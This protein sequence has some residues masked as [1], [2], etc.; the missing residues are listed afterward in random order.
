MV[1]ENELGGR[2]LKYPPADDRIRTRNFI[3]V[4]SLYF[5]KEGPKIQ[6]QLPV[7]SDLLRT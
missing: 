1:R 2:D 6:P 7:R 4:A 5:G 3:N